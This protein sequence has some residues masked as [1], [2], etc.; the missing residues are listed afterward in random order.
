MVALP[1]VLNDQLAQASD[2]FETVYGQAESAQRLLE[3]KISEDWVAMEDNPRVRMP[4]EGSAS[5]WVQHAVSPGRKGEE[6]SREK[7]PASKEPA[8]KETVRRYLSV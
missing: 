1:E 5:K 2:D 4:A 7:V 3:S 6:R 8:S